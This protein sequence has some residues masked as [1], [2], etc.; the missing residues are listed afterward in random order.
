[1]GEP[2]VHG[3]GETLVEARRN[4]RDVITTLF[5][6]FEAEGD[7][8]ELVEDVRL[9]EAVLAIVAQAHGERTLANRRREEARVAKEAVAVATE[10]ALMATRRAAGLV[11]EHGELM[12]AVADSCR[13]ADDVRLPELLVQAVERAHVARESARRLAETAQA[14]QRAAKATAS[15]ANVS[16]REAARMLTQRC[17]LSKDEAARLLGLSSE[18]VQ[19]LLTG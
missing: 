13:L 4:I 19:R 18:R 2:T 12:E 16:N 15:E 1:V 8:F 11:V 6:P 5:G 17:G 3:Y 7:G 9:P 14:A 10:E